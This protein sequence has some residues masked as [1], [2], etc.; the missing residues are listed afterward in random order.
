M[1]SFLSEKA[2]QLI[3]QARIVSF[4]AWET[5]FSPEV[6]QI[7]QVADDEGRYLNDEDL[8]RLRTLAPDRIHTF[9][10]VQM[11]RDRAPE[12]VAEARAQVLTQ[13][14]TIADPGGD[15]YPPM[16][17]EACWRDFWHFLRCI[18]YGIAGQ[19][20]QY[21]SEAG[22]QAMELLYQ[23]LRVPLPAMV[24]GLEGVKAASLKRLP[25]EPPERL[26][27]Y[28]DRLIDQLKQ[29]SNAASS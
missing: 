16:R 2:K 28:F 25:A 5:F 7:Y 4:A 1:S 6:I 9:E 10:L 27:P 17:A 12:I 20:T 18:T 24:L 21:T 22:L 8:Q 14:P 11:L 23:E 13:F 3:A 19:S 26:A 15:L 29:F